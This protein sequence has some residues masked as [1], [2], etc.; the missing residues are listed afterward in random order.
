MLTTINK[1]KMKW[2]LVLLWALVPIYAN[3]CFIMGNTSRPTISKQGSTYIA[4]YK[5][6]G[7]FGPQLANETCAIDEIQSN[8]GRTFTNLGYTYIGRNWSVKNI[9]SD[10]AVCALQVKT[11]GSSKQLVITYVFPA[12]LFCN[13]TFDIDIPFTGTYTGTN[14]TGDIFYTPSLVF[15]FNS[16]TVSEFRFTSGSGIP[17]PSEPAR[18][19]KLTHPGIV[20]MKKTNPSVFS[21]SSIVVFAGN[22]SVTLNCDA[23]TSARSGIPRLILTYP[24]AIQGGLCVATNQA[25]PAV[26]SPVSVQI[27]RTNNSIVCGDSAIGLGSV[28]DFATFTNAAA[29]SST[30]DFNTLYIAKTSNPAPGIFTT[31]VTLQVSYP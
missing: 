17:I 19:C 30:L 12:L 23:T 3:A 9:K 25:D 2:V 4:T 13:I 24:S 20:T 18:T 6:T 21:S 7:G 29:Y 28:Q 5:I 16:R 1:L 22:F 15:T 14:P 10:S 26:A 8:D 27:K 11:I 31:S